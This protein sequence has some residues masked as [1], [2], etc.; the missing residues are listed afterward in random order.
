MK[1]YVWFLVIL[2]SIGV[3]PQA[4]QTAVPSTFRIQGKVTNTNGDPLPVTSVKYKLG[5]EPTA[6]WPVSSTWPT[7]W[8]DVAA[9]TTN[10][11]ANPG[12]FEVQI[13]ATPAVFQANAIKFY[14]NGSITT[15]FQLITSV[16]YAYRAKVAESIA[17]GAKLNLPYSESVNWPGAAVNIANTNVTSG[18]ATAIVSAANR[19]GVWGVASGGMSGINQNGVGAGVIGNNLGNPA[20]PAYNPILA[21]GVYGG[22]AG[23]GVMGGPT[24]IP[25]YTSATPFT[26]GEAKNCTYGVIG[27]GKVSGAAGFGVTTGVVGVG[28]KYGV[29]AIGN[30]AG[31][32]ARSPEIAIL[33]TGTVAGST[34]KIGVMG[35]GTERGVMGQSVN[36]SYHYGILGGDFPEK[37]EGIE[38]DPMAGSHSIVGAYGQANKGLVRAYL[39]KAD[40]NPPASMGYDILYGPLVSSYGVLAYNGLT[41][42]GLAYSTASEKAGLYAAAEGNQVPGA[43]IKSKSGDGI[44]VTT[45]KTQYDAVYAE[46]TTGGVKAHL[47]GYA[48]SAYSGV[49]G[50][51]NNAY[52]YGGYFKNDS[53]TALHAVTESNSKAA[54][55]AT[56]AKI[57]DSTFAEPFMTYYTEKTLDGAGDVDYTATT[58][59]DKYIMG[60]MISLARHDSLLVWENGAWKTA[61]G[62]YFLRAPRVTIN[63]STGAVNIDANG[64]EYAYG[65]CRL[66]VFYQP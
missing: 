14:I 20:W 34:P 43:L 64:D 24:L 4:A 51:A 33:G 63:Q 46:H 1:K 6:D 11:T 60:I 47:A 18:T 56:S 62:N 28:T 22:S 49:Y 54:L 58:L 30:T 50:Y 55:D 39:A 3:I 32:I 44:K 61:D 35:F 38:F 26:S 40:Y 12:L 53:G 10:N 25:D 2:I 29:E 15:P 41:K 59:K 52:K 13:L 42:A 37:T 8:S 27:S 17:G 48:E 23:V 5:L 45:E 36:D 16:P 7:D 9:I 65:K 66:F 31:V 21:I 57:G 19:I